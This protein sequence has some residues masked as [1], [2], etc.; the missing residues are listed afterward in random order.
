MRSGVVR[1]TQ[2][3]AAAAALALL[4]HC[5]G[6]SITTS[7]T[8]TRD[9]FPYPSARAD[10][11]RTIA[12]EFITT[13]WCG[14]PLDVLDDTRAAEIAGAG[15][16]LIGASCEG[17]VNRKLNE[18]ALAVAQRHGLRMLIKDPR[19][20]A[21]KDLAGKWKVRANRAI[22]DYRGAPALAGFFLID[23]PHSDRYTDIAALRRRLRAKA[24]ELIGY[25]NMLP[26]YVFHSDDDYQEYLESYLFKTQPA[27]L[28]YDY[29]PFRK[30]ED[31]PSYF[32]NLSLVRRLALEY[33]IPFMAIVQLMPHADY[34]D[35]SEGEL[36]W[37][38]FHPL[39]FGARGISYFAYW[40][41]SRVRDNNAYRFRNGIIEGGLP[42]QHYPRVQRLNRTIRSIAAQLGGFRSTA[43]W[44]S[45]GKLAKAK[46]RS[47]LASVTSAHPLTV[48]FFAKESKRAAIVVN[49][50]YD[51]VNQI[52]LQAVGGERI[53]VF[54]TGQQAWGDLPQPLSV[55]PGAAVLVRLA[56][57]Q[58]DD[59]VRHQTNP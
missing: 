33:G 10:R 18:K 28:S 29:Y 7:P 16:N 25:V 57:G 15:F 53:E 56:N 2:S 17:P 40:T 20:S 21:Y 9:S 58:R 39:A 8:Q 55:E 24:P 31:R 27:L 32:A 46:L 43:V 45:G 19:M 48:G 3:A 36:A 4:L 13:F 23:E 37:Q 59:G 35:V 44:D 51:E 41:P 38:V 26:D 30:D 14:P 11:P 34:R 54:D 5:F 1:T 12:D 42:S 22:A 49:Q 52:T 47:P 50:S 6:C